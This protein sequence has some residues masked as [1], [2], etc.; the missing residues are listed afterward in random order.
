MKDYRKILPE[1]CRIEETL[2]EVCGNSWALNSTQ[3]ENDSGLFHVEWVFQVMD[4]YTE[5]E[6]NGG[7]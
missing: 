6:E 7:S 3:Y 2:E 4:H 1:E 5:P